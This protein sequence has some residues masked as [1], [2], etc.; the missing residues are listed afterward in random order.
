MLERNA[1]P[2][3]FVSATTEGAANVL[4]LIEQRPNPVQ[5]LACDNANPLSQIARVGGCE[6]QSIGHG[7]EYFG[8][9]MVRIRKLLGHRD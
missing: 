1:S 8:K 4:G 9:P 7:G 5:G 3:A 6:R 2:V